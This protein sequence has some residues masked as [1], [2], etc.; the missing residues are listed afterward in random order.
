MATS[1]LTPPLTEE[2]KNAP[3]GMSTIDGGVMS[4]MNDV[5][6]AQQPPEPETPQGVPKVQL[7]SN[8]QSPT[9]VSTDSMRDQ[10]SQAERDLK[11]MKLQIEAANQPTQKEEAEATTQQ[12][13]TQQVEQKI[14]APD[15]FIT[16][17]Q[18]ETD[19]LLR[20]RER[21]F[22]KYLS[23]SGGILKSQ[24]NAIKANF[25]QRRQQAEKVAANAKAVTGILGAR[26][27]RLRYAP[28]IQQG[29]LTG[30]ENALI[31]TLTEI[32]AMELAAIAEAESAAFD[33]DYDTFLDKIGSLDTIKAARENTLSELEQA[34]KEENERRAEEAE[35]LENE[36]MI[37]EQFANGLTN[38]IEI[39]SALNGKVPYDMV[40][41][42]AGSLPA[43]AGGSEFKFIP[44]T[45]YQ[46]SGYFD[47]TTGQFTPTGG[48]VSSGG[49]LSIGGQSVGMVS[50]SMSSDDVDSL[51]IS[52]TAKALVKMWK[53]GRISH[54]DLLIQLKGDRVDRNLRNEVLGVI[55]QLQEP[56]PAIDENVSVYNRNQANTAI[57]AIDSILYRFSDE[58]DKGL[59]GF[60][61]T[62][63]T[64]VGR[65]IFKFIPGTQARNV[66][67]KLDTVR[68]LIGFDALQKMREASP[69][70]GALGQITER[71]LAFLQ[72]VEGSL[73]T[74]QSSDELVTTLQR[75]RKSFARVRAINSPDMTADEYKRMF[76]DAT[77]Q[78]LSELR[79]RKETIDNAQ[80]PQMSNMDLFNA[81]SGTTST[82]MDE[83]DDLFEE[84]GI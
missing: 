83:V 66:E 52:D 38:P 65:T 78:E 54:E 30:Q 72:S 24:V 55:A 62:S 51:N 46:Q 68:A 21:Q 3:A 56:A 22:D 49:V 4:G 12:V 23:R 63:N 45:K 8:V 6:V 84:I 43:G 9:V 50:A 1:T 80:A 32:D 7:E 81:V 44:G 53:E 58:G 64:A 57:D 28:E 77:E 29:I 20:D 71:E 35:K 27:G 18:K 47:P 31:T 61:D 75:I 34:M 69:T 10:L 37:I 11:A 79:T 67:A 60:T 16:D 82:E 33:R 14:P 59:A 48:R 74:G 26:T 73:D 39:Y 19:K 15:D 5:P 36:S 2:E 25:D 70:G 17:Y 40:V 76:P 41:E 13:G 42:Y